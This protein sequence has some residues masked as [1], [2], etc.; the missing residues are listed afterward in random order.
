[1][2]SK[3]LCKKINCFFALRE[4]GSGKSDRH[5][6]MRME[7]YPPIV[8]KPFFYNNHSKISLH[9]KV[10]SRCSNEEDLLTFLY[11]TLIVSLYINWKY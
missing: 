10:M 5:K 11:K 7:L 1:M 4:L 8:K 3:K 9:H 2:S 6:S